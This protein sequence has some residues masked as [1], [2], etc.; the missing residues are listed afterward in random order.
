MRTERIESTGSRFPPATFSGVGPRFRMHQLKWLPQFLQ[1]KVLT[2]RISHP[3]VKRLA[4]CRK[5]PKLK[6]NRT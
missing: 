1:F 5:H 4:P 3:K 2:V 6:P